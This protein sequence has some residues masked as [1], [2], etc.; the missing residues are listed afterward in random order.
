MIRYVQN[1]LIIDKLASNTVQRSGTEQKAT[2]HVYH[3]PPSVRSYASLRHRTVK[4]QSNRF[5]HPKRRIPIDGLSAVSR[6][7]S[8]AVLISSVTNKIPN[9]PAQNHAR[10]QVSQS[11][12]FAPSPF[13]TRPGLPILLSSQLEAEG[14]LVA[15]KHALLSTGEEFTQPRTSLPNIS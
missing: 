1:C 13:P 14:S 5:S 4:S 7:N 2:H 8:L 6:R 10:H 3:V 12:A 11:H 9:S 15:E